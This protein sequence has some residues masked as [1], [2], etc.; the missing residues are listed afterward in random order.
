M[1]NY[2]IE[3]SALITVNE[4]WVFTEEAES[5]EIAREKAIER[6][7]QYIDKKYA[8][9][10]LARHRDGSEDNY[11]KLWTILVFARWYDL[12]LLEKK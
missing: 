4:S 2:D 6:F 1:K 8:L 9:E 3:V 5:Y 10:L 12:L 7:Q 11:R